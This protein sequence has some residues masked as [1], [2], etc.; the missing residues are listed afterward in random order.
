MI[1]YGSSDL[2]KCTRRNIALRMDY[3]PAKPPPNMQKVFDAGHEYEAA[4]IDRLGFASF[5]FVTDEKPCLG[6]WDTCTQYEVVFKVTNDVIVLAHLDGKCVDYEDAGATIEIKSMSEQV[7]KS[8]PHNH[9]VWD[10]EGLIQD[11]KWQISVPMVVRKL[12]TVVFFGCRDSDEF[13]EVSVEKPFYN[14]SEIRA[15]VLSIEAAAR[16]GLLPESC[17]NK[18]YPCPVYYAT[19]CQGKVEYGNEEVANLGITYQKIR[20]EKKNLDDREKRLRHQ[21]ITATGESGIVEKKYG[22]D[23]ATVSFYKG[24]GKVATDWSKVVEDY[25]VEVEKYQKPGNDWQ[26]I[27]VTRKDQ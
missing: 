9:N 22:A 25:N 13:F 5:D 4:F 12:P 3:E 8:V 2:G 14:E 10:V 19:G 26:G 15:R 23:S 1:V 24:K 27:R 20:D 17:D 16:Q 21:L 6:R 18:S 7:Y 11:Y